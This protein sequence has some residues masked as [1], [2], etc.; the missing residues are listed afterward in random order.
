MHQDHSDA[1][2]EPL[3]FTG[4][5][6]LLCQDMVARLPDVLGHI[7]MDRVA[8]HNL[9]TQPYG[10]SDIGSQKA[11]MLGLRSPALLRLWPG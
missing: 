8:E 6:R 11:K 5:M 1:G 2:R 3:D 9:S 4:R 7:D 10:R